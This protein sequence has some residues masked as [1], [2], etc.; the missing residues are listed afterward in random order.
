M[1]MGHNG[2]KRT[3]REASASEL[4]D[5]RVGALPDWRGRALT[6]IRELL[7][8]VDP[9]LLEEWKW[10]GLRISDRGAIICTV[11]TYKDRV[12]ITS[13]DCRIQRVS[14]R[15]GSGAKAG[16]QSTST[17]ARRSTRRRSR[18]SCVRR[19]L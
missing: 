18:R 2:H 5:A 6:R 8:E 13:P 11:E 17:R 3:W 16:V 7:R 15:R 10:R 12:R 19:S 1:Q 9:N 4:I 14:S